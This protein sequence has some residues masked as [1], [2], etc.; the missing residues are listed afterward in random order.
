MSAWQQPSS[1]DL[2]LL[3][4]MLSVGSP[5]HRPPGHHP[6]DGGERAGD[7][8]APPPG[9]PVPFQ[10]GKRPVALPLPAPPQHP[11]RCGIHLKEQRG[12]G[13]MP[14]P[15]QISFGHHGKPFENGEFILPGDS[16]GLETEG[17]RRLR[18]WP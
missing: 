18:G 17:V 10:R 5:P 2:D 12:M 1:S 6:V 3:S 4:G 7:G 14:E 9:A 13:P 8:P 15:M 16:E 11:L